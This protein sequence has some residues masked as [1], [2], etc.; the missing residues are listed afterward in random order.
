MM[1]SVVQHHRSSDHLL[2]KLES[3]LQQH[4]QCDPTSLGKIESTHTLALTLLGREVVSD[5]ILQIIN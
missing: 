3:L 2:W 5:K 1:L 4:I